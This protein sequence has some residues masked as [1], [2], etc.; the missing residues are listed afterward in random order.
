MQ[1]A[2]SLMIASVGSTIVGRS[3]WSTRTSPGAYMTTAR[4][5][6]PL[7]RCAHQGTSFLRGWGVPDEGCTAGTPLTVDSLT[8][9]T[10]PTVEGM[11]NRA[12]VREFLMSRRAKVSPD[13]AGV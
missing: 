6:V 13:T 10:G 4:M 1:V 3:V 12:D 11:D 5:V 9:R 2:A 7:C 8:D